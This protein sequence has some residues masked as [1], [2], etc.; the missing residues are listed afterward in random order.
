MA[1]EFLYRADPPGQLAG[2]DIATLVKMQAEAGLNVATPGRPLSPEEMKSDP[3]GAVARLSADLKAARAATDLPVKLCMPLPGTLRLDPML[4]GGLIGNLITEGAK[5]LEFD[6]RPYRDAALEPGDDGFT[7]SGLQRPEGFRIAI[8]MGA[9]ADWDA[10][11]LAEV[12]EELAADRYVLDI[13]ADGDDFSKLGRLPDTSI[14]VLGL[15]DPSGRQEGDALLAILDAAGEAFDQ[16]RM[17]LTARGGFTAG[18]AA[19]QSA[20]MAQLA[21]IAVRYWG[22]AM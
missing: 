20:T 9:L 21:D 22:F 16:D 7:L 11:R 8:Q 10:A 12:A 6:G 15:I 19:N 3:H 5:I 13:G 4:L 17:A 14:A 2:G 18:D 1:D